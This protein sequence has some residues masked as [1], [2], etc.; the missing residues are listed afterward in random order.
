MYET[1]ARR[2]AR[3]I[4]AKYHDGPR[5][6]ALATAPDL[7]TFCNFGLE[8]CY[9]TWHCPVSP[10][11]PYPATALQTRSAWIDVGIRLHD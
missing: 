5:I 2:L 10:L 3:D 4:Y 9:R 1:L 11:Y 6:F 8:L 7:L